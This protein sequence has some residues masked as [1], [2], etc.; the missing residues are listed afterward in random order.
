MGNYAIYVAGAVHDCDVN[1]FGLPHVVLG[2]GV[3]VSGKRESIWV[4][5]F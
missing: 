2:E 4:R 5:I 3:T 1:R